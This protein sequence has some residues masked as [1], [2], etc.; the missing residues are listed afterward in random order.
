MGKKKT[1][2]VALG[3]NAISPKGELDTIANQFRN[4]RKSRKAI[5]RLIEKGYNLA[6]THG[7]G[8]QVGNALLRVE[9]AEG[10][11]PIIPLGI[12]VADTE[13]GMGYMIEQSL[14][15]AIRKIDI[16]RD[17]VTIATQIIVDGNDPAIKNPQKY[18]GGWYTEREINA[19]A[20]KFDWSIKEVPNKGWRRVVPSPT[21]LE[22][23]N[24]R[25][26]KRLVDEGVVV[27]AAGGGGI[28]VYIDENGDYEGVDGVI[29]KDLASAVLAHDIGAEELF[30]LTDVDQVAINF[31]K[32][33][34]QNLGK[35]TYDE[36]KGYF[37]EGQFPPGS[38][39]PKIQAALSFLENGGSKVIITSL[40]SVKDDLPDDKITLI[41]K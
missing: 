15:N 32:E 13:G 39:G 7:N 25:A 31:G 37:D 36:L 40:D 24:K 3:G 30:I 12:C 6:V 34:Q 17:V 22:I 38:M 11:A 18:V 1:A 4:T 21:P 16:D 41:T 35:V 26:I 28:P 2:V 33:N 20:K 14:Q 10:K 5:I 27:I 19:L 8:P 23:I 29:D 9:A